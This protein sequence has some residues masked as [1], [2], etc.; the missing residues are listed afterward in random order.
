[1][2]EEILQDFRIARDLNN[3]CSPTGAGK[4]S[5]DSFPS[6]HFALRCSG[7]CLKGEPLLFRILQLFSHLFKE[8]QESRESWT[9]ARKQKHERGSGIVSY[10]FFFRTPADTAFFQAIIYRIITTYEVQ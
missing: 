8:I 10:A 7:A 4:Y 5:S 6:D 9:R 2:R 3:F 1:M